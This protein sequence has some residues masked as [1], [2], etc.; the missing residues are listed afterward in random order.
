MRR[1]MGAVLDRAATETDLARTRTL[2]ASYAEAVRKRFGTRVGRIR[3]YGSVVRGDWAQESDI[4]VQVA[5]DRIEAEDG[6]WLAQSAFRMGILDQG[7]PSCNP[8]SWR[9]TIST[10][11]SAGSALLLSV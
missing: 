8:Y 7:L 10:R 6:D 2:A 5:L 11:Y 4:D 1:E 3:L 9:R